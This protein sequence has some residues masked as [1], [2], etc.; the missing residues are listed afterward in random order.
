MTPLGIK[1]ATCWFVA[2]CLKL[3][4]GDNNKFLCTYK[5]SI[6]APIMMKFYLKHLIRWQQY[7]KAYHTAVSKWH[8]GQ[9]TA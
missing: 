6:L 9:A 7:H 4:F 3:L 1:P 5:I 8:N 2:Q